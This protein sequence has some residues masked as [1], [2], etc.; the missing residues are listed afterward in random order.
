VERQNSFEE[1]RGRPQILI[2]VLRE[3]VTPGYGHNVFPFNVE[4]ESPLVAL[5]LT[6]Q[7]NFV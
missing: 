6:S 4:P 1:W 2:H 7:H 3:V 5:V